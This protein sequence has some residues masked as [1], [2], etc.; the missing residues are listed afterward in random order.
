MERMM[1]RV[2]GNLDMMIGVASM[3]L[4]TGMLISI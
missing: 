4:R 2:A 3:P 1:T